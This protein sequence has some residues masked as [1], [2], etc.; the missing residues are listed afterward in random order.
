MREA[1]RRV[2]FV[3]NNCRRTKYPH[4][5]MATD[6]KHQKITRRKREDSPQ[7]RVHS[8]KNNSVPKLP[9]TRPPPVQADSAKSRKQP[10]AEPLGKNN[11]VKIEAFTVPKPAAATITEHEEGH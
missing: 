8:H 10:V 4:R 9:V 1:P 2:N 3:A 5:F 11:N 6:A 7:R